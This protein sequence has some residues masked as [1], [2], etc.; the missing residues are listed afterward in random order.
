[1]MTSY[2]RPGV[3][4]EDKLS[5]K[6]DMESKFAEVNELEI[7]VGDQQYVSR[8]NGAQGNLNKS[9]STLKDSRKMSMTSL[10]SRRR[11]AD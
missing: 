3:T 8:L 5:L 1:M 11:N 7:L 6:S 10:P 9:K 2:L 4:D